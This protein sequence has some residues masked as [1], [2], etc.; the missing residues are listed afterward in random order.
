L[1]TPATDGGGLR[2][3]ADKVRLDL[4][5]AEW[6]IVLGEILTG[7]AKKYAPR[8]WERGME[9]SKMIASLMRHLFK[10]LCGEIYDKESR[11]PHMGH[12][13]WNALA[14]MSYDLRGIGVD[15][16]AEYALKHPTMLPPI[17][18]RKKKDA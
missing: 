13:A 2:Y 15:D 14:L 1:S 6:V 11:S 18:K 10:R 5:P 7:G 4:I 3:N 12:V 9:Y 17:R 16:L 8:N